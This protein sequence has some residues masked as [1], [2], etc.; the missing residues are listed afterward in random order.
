MNPAAAIRILLLAS[1]LPVPA[2]GQVAAT[3]NVNTTV[4]PTRAAVLSGGRWNNSFLPRQ[5][6]LSHPMGGPALGPNYAAA[7]RNASGLVTVAPA[8]GAPAALAT[9]VPQPVVPARPAAATPAPGSKLPPL[10]Q[11]LAPPAPAPAPR[12]A[13]QSAQ[14]ARRVVEVQKARAK[15]GSPEAQFDL[16][17]RYMNG[18]GVMPDLERAR[19]WL[20][21]A[22]LSGHAAAARKLAELDA[23]PR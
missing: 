5:P 8:P 17:V 6:V 7:G 1:V 10:A 20:T 16:G 12:Q 21:E 4:V 9:R 13:S 22:A 18:D 14:V 2:F 11:V 15:E 19:H 3:I 23:L